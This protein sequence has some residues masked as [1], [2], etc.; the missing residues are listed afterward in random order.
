MRVIK[1]KADC[2]VTLTDATVASKTVKDNLP[3]QCI[4]KTRTGTYSMTGSK[5]MLFT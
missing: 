3:I 4:R 5:I 1:P 2:A